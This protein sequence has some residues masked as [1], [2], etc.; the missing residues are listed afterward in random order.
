MRVVGFYRCFWV[1]SFIC[2][3]NYRVIED[4]NCGI[5]IFF[6]IVFGIVGVFSRVLK[7]VKLSRVFYIEVRLVKVGMRVGFFDFLFI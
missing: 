4:I 1:N 7:N 3:I 2:F 5:L 6:F